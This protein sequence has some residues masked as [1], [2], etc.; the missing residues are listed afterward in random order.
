L[1]QSA[2]LSLQ[3]IVYDSIFL[4]EVAAPLITKSISFMVLS[5]L[6]IPES[7]ALGK[8]EVREPFG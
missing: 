7:L 8:V 5:K 6:F 4:E 3:T 1:H 2:A